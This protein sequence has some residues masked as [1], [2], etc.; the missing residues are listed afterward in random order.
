MQS[1]PSR[2]LADRALTASWAS[3]GHYAIKDDDVRVVELEN[4]LPSKM[5]LV[6]LLP[7]GSVQKGAWLDGYATSRPLVRAD[8]TLVFFRDGSLYVA[9]DLSIDASV[10]LCAPNETLHT[11]PVVGDRESAYVSYV[12]ESDSHRSGLLERV[13]V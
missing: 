1:P 3:H 12:R 7:G 10:V 5:H 9:R 2:L 8:G 13:V 11:L 6:R 4:V